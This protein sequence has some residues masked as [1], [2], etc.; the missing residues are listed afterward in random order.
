MKFNS[1]AHFQPAMFGQATSFKYTNAST[2]VRANLLPATVELTI[3][4]LDPTSFRRN[5]SIPVQNA[6]VSPDDLP[7]MT[8]AFSK[9][10]IANNIR[11]AR[12]FST[13]V[14]LVNSGQR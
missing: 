3:V 6:Q 10:L 14:N 2:T 8:T 12:T 11:N 13:R 5:P 1:A 4:T 9:A 7:N